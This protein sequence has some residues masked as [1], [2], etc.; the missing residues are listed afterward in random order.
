M[1]DSFSISDAVQ[2]D[3]LTAPP[4][5]SSNSDSLESKSKEA[6]GENNVTSAGADEGVQMSATQARNG[7]TPEARTVHSRVTLAQVDSTAVQGSDSMPSQNEKQEDITHV[8]PAEPHEVSAADT[9]GAALNSITSSAPAANTGNQGS[10][11]LCCC[12]T[13]HGHPHVSTNMLAS[14]AGLRLPP[15]SALLAA[16]FA[17][18]PLNSANLAAAEGALPTSAFLSAY[19]PVSCAYVVANTTSAISAGG[20]VDIIGANGLN[21]MITQ[22]P[23]IPPLSGRVPATQPGTVLVPVQTSMFPIVCPG[24]AHSSSP[25]ERETSVQPADGNA[26]PM[27]MDH[28]SVTNNEAVSS[29][30]SHTSPQ[31]INTPDNGFNK[32]AA[33][34]ID[35]SSTPVS[36]SPRNAISLPDASGFVAA[37]VNM[38]PVTATNGPDPSVF[39]ESAAAAGDRNPF[40]SATNPSKFGAIITNN[41]PF[42][43]TPTKERRNSTGKHTTTHAARRY[44]TKHKDA[45]SIHGS[46][47]GA[48]NTTSVRYK[49]SECLQGFSRPSSLKIHT[50]SHTGERPFVCDYNGCGK[51]F[52]VRSNMRR[53]QRVHGI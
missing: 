1:H 40:M 5:A 23:V 46:V 25:Q 6:I 14:T 11:S 47:N 22:A 48:G 39:P 42:A 44:S 50:Y 26:R 36:S 53:H 30:R 35:L 17:N 38:P 34:I 29:A 49:C 15:I 9:A 33:S 12:T 4:T 18:P 19:P 27:D 31:P 51:A 10:P 21:T 2:A 8:K 13:V 7:E 43:P 37:P 24:C 32:R 28:P 16:T 20:H 45:Q 41:V 3:S 52:N